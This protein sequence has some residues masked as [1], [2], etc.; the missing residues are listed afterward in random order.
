MFFPLSR[1]H[2]LGLVAQN[3]NAVLAQTSL[4]MALQYEKLGFT[5]EVVDLLAQGE[6]ERLPQR[7]AKG[8]IAFVYAFAGVGSRLQ[9]M[10]DAHLW[11]HYKIP[12]ASFWYDHP[13]YNYRQHTIDSPYVL[14]IY[15]VRD[16]Y[17]IKQRYFG[18]TSPSILMPM[19][20]QPHVK[21]DQKPWRSRQNR[22]LYAKTADNPQAYLTRW[23]QFGPRLEGVLNEIAAVAVTDRNS[24]LAQITKDVFDAHKMPI[25][26]LDTFMGSIQEVD[27]YIRA[28]RSDRLARALLRFPAHIIG[29]GWDYLPKDKAQATFSDAVRFE[30]YH[31]M[32]LDYKIHANSSPLWRDGIH[33]RVN[34]ALASGSIALT[35]RSQRSDAYYSDLESY[36]GFEWNDP[37]EDSITQS[38]AKANDPIGFAEAAKERILKKLPIDNDSYWLP[39]I[40]TL[41]TLPQQ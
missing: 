40:K 35:D 18:H 14:N 6:L 24:D 3:E 30:D 2:V 20:Q 41:A 11:T 33:E 27:R 39:I 1:T 7:L 13:C 32:L 22:I 5:T 8:N 16:H 19:I 34:L 9:L 15:H 25:D 31:M 23:K 36:I 17:D 21:A 28:E 29:R 4:S 12:F 37:I 10:N 38:L 26:D